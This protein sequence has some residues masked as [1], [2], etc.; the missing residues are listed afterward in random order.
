LEA[1]LPKEENFPIPRPAYSFS[2]TKG[3]KLKMCFLMPNH[4]GQK[5]RRTTSHQLN[6][7]Q[8]HSILYSLYLY[9]C[10]SFIQ[11]TLQHCQYLHTKWN[12]QTI[13]CWLITNTNTTRFIT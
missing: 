11:T 10:T 8:S 4:R 13:K 12:A 2:L 5:H 3:V 9:V 6:S 7:P 1:N